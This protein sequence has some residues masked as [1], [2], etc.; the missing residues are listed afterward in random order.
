[1]TITLRKMLLDAKKIVE[2]NPDALD[3]PVFGHDTSSGVIYHDLDIDEREL[4]KCDIDMG[5]FDDDDVGRKHIA[6]YLE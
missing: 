2:K 1:M 4:Q 3:Y 5:C 6:I